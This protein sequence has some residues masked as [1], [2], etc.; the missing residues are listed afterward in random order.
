M[1]RSDRYI[2]REMYVIQQ[3]NQMTGNFHSPIGPFPHESAALAAFDRI[4]QFCNEGNG[5]VDYVLLEP[6]LMILTID[7]EDLQLEI[8]RVVHLSQ[9]FDALE[10]LTT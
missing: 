4:I 3:Y 7:N 9:Q 6:T 10:D 5:R 1:P 2:D 8:K